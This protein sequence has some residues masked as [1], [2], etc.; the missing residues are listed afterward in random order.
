MLFCLIA[1]LA[2][3]R[4]EIVQRM[5]APVNTQADGLVRVFA[6]C[7]EDMR[8]EYQSPVARFAADTVALLYRGE[9]RKPVRFER[10]GIII[11]LGDVRTNI[12]DVVARVTTN[13]NEVTTRIYLKSPGG[14]D[15]GRFRTEVVRAFYRAV[16][17]RE[18]SDSDAREK[19]N[20]FDPEY[21]VAQRRAQLE[22]WLAG[23]RSK[24]GTVHDETWDEEHLTLLRKVLQI[25]VSSRR[26]VL[27]FA[28]RLYLYPLYFDEAFEG[29]R[30][31][32][33]FKEAIH[34]ARKDLRIRLLAM[35]KSVEVAVFG[36]GRSEELASAAEAYVE[37]LQELS[38]GE[39]SEKEMEDLLLNADKRLEL[40]FERAREFGG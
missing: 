15:L 25:G 21:Q 10:P 3:T 23:D 39:K 31:S 27:T 2:L 12:T 34:L 11:H 33:S 32:L 26:D 20:S 30:R 17:R 16:C 5:R 4:A 14:A 35:K 7:P 29:G 24:Q 9:K 37:F 36:G 28:S 6:N 13:E 22:A 40:A 38:K 19:F 18:L 1:M 8:R